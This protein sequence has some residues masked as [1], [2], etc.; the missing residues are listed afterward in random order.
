MTAY[1]NQECMDFMDALGCN[2]NQCQPVA[3]P[4][5]SHWDQWSLIALIL[6]TGLIVVRRVRPSRTV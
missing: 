6:V 5:M 3:V 2:A 1:T 4:A